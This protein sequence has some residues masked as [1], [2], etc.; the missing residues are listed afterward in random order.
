MADTGDKAAEAS[1]EAPAQ[2]ETAVSH[3]SEDEKRPA[4]TQ[5]DAEAAPTA[6]SKREVEDAP[7]PDSDD[8]D[9]LDGNLRP[10]PPSSPPY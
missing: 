3:H 8:L 9:D 2:S 7:D 4:P 1:T 10:G 6:S 5:K